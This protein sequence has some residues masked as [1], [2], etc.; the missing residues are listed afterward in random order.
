MQRAPGTRQGMRARQHC[1]KGGGE[2]VRRRCSTPTTLPLP[3]PPAVHRSPLHSLGVHACAYAADQEVWLRHD[4]ALLNQQCLK[5][6]QSLQGSSIASCC[7]HAH[8]EE[9]GG[10]HQ[11][12][13]RAHQLHVQLACTTARHTTKSQRCPPRP[14]CTPMRCTHPAR[15]EH[16]PPASC[17]A[18]FS[19]PAGEFCRGSVVPDHRVVQV[20]HQHL[21]DSRGDSREE[22][23]QVRPHVRRQ[24]S[25][26][27]RT[28]EGR[29]LRCSTMQQQELLKG[30]GPRT[31]GPH[32]DTPAPPR[33]PAHYRRRRGLRQLATAQPPAP[34]ISDHVVGTI[35]RL[36]PSV[37]PISDNKLEQRCRRAAAAGVAGHAAAQR[38]VRYCHV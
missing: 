36:V 28:N 21:R 16:Q 11:P 10:R 33:A 26:S 20:G 14:A 38:A 9:T 29:L 1:R 37:L 31:A 12:C 23:E 35:R 27:Q 2:T 34:W 4:A 17:H 24:A 3:M 5:Q 30:R 18:L 19:P 32:T 15:V 25:A 8:A 7:M 13:C 22:R 6:V